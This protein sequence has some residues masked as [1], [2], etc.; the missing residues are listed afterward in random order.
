MA[1]VATSDGE[2]F[3]E[4]ILE[5]LAGKGHNSPYIA[6]FTRKFVANRHKRDFDEYPIAELAEMIVSA[7]QFF[8]TKE[9]TAPKIQV[10]NA[11]ASGEPCTIVHILNNDMP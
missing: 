9:S 8:R 5:E 4:E 1:L 11:T 10:S 2:H 6:S 7:Q 3:V